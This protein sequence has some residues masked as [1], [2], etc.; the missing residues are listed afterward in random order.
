[1]RCLIPTRFVS[2]MRQV[3]GVSVGYERFPWQWTHNTREQDKDLTRSR[4]M[5][6]NHSGGIS[7]DVRKGGFSCHTCFLM[8]V[9]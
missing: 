4:I 8:R 9:S 6:L 2:P 5:S 1:M 3:G 7:G